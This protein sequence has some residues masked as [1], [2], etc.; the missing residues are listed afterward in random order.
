MSLFPSFSLETMM[1]AQDNMACAGALA[2][3]GKNP[4]AALVQCT[5]AG[6]AA[7]AGIPRDVF[8]YSAFP[9]LP[10]SPNSG[11]IPSWYLTL[12]LG[13][14]SPQERLAL[15]V[16]NTGVLTTNLALNFANSTNYA[17]PL[18][19]VDFVTSTTDIAAAWFAQVL[20]V[21]T[22][23]L[24][25]RAYV[26]NFRTARDTLFEQAMGCPCSAPI[27]ALSPYCD[28][29]TAYRAACYSA[30]I[31]PAACE[32]AIKLYGTMGVR[33]LFGNTR[34]PLYTALQVA[35]SAP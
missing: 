10:T 22:D 5:K 2:N 4:S 23:S 21:S 3:G 17:P 28:V 6:Y 32:L 16:A 18:Q 24:T 1:Q 11:T 13:V 25:Y 9:S 8:A 15:V 12:P 27:P 26:I 14:I 19:C 35:R 29:L 33:D 30:H 20:A 34:E 31:I 7:L